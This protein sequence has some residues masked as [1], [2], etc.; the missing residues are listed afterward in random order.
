MRIFRKLFK[1]KTQV[2]WD[3]RIAFAVEGA[4]RDRARREGNPA[5]EDSGRSVPP[6]PGDGSAFVAS[7]RAL[8]EEDFA[9]RPFTYHPP[10]YGP[11]GVL[12]AK[13][14][15]VFPEIGPPVEEQ[16][17]RKGAEDVELWMSGADSFGPGPSED[18]ADGA[19]GDFISGGSDRSTGFDH[20][21][22]GA[23]D[24]AGGI[25]GD[26]EAAPGDSGDSLTDILNNPEIGYPF[27]GGQEDD[28]GDF[29]FDLGEPVAQVSHGDTAAAHTQDPTHP[30][31]HPL[32]SPEKDTSTQPPSMEPT[33]QPPGT[34]AE[35]ETQSFDH[36]QAA[37]AAQDQLM[38]LQNI[39][40]DSSAA[41]QL[42][43]PINLG[44]SIL[45][46]RKMSPE[47]EEDGISPDGRQGKKQ[48]QDALPTDGEVGNEV[49]DKIQNA[50]LAAPAAETTEEV[51]TEGDARVAGDEQVGGEM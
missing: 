8:N 50:D 16:A 2:E 45:G 18:Q 38:E 12:P 40:Q 49:E 36:T 1:E 20:L 10:L 51:E 3:D 24:A 39:P 43:A 26:G 37:L 13:E 35:T 44:T 46:K 47:N 9:K 28:N 32:A 22:S 19:G 7:F 15:E 23:L 27:T 17:R 4:K 34:P 42:K 14:K 21:M 30:P 6:V 48:Q 11:C 41:Q 29:S 31:S 33:T 5:N 25:T